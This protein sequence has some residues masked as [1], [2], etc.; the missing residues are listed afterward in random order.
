[1]VVTRSSVVFFVFVF[2]SFV[3]CV[4]CSK[5]YEYD[6]DGMVTIFENDICRC[7]Y[8]FLKHCYECKCHGTDVSMIVGLTIGIPVGLTIL[9][10]II[11]FAIFRCGVRGDG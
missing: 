8:G 10:V 3:S 1:M 4:I 6:D 7:D 2:V 5:C 11:I 9:V